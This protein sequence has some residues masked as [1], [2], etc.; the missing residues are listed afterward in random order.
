MT[1]APRIDPRVRKNVKIKKVKVNGAKQANGK[2]TDD[3]RDANEAK[4]TGKRAVIKLYTG[5][6]SSIATKT[7]KMLF[8]A[9]VPLY[10][11]SDAL[12]RPIIKKV[13]AS[14]GKTTKV[15]QLK[16]LNTVYLRDLTCRHADFLR[17]DGRSKSWKKAI[18]PIN[19]AATILARSRRLPASSPPRPCGLT[20]HSSLIKDTM[21]QR[22]SS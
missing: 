22:G 16:E 4:S 20:G 17:Y 5:E 21:I 2:T 6:H 7:E 10:Q 3:E 15:A 8:D 19:I 1:G 18:A 9:G 14:H 11:R 12:M 13:D